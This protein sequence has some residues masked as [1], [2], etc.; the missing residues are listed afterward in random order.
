MYDFRN[1]LH[2][3]EKAQIISLET[4]LRWCPKVFLEW[5]FSIIQVITMSY[6]SELFTNRG[7]TG[8]V[9][10]GC[11]PLH[12]EILI[13]MNEM[14]FGYQ[15]H[16]WN[17]NWFRHVHWNLLSVQILLVWSK[18]NTKGNLLGRQCF[19][20]ADNVG[21]FMIYHSKSDESI[22]E[23]INNIVFFLYKTSYNSIVITNLWILYLKKK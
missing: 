15:N 4:T 6:D 14:I 17:K 5:S 16:T 11:N 2:V 10:L 23:S 12:W 19:S 9:I 13:C 8:L 21:N 1:I 7:E 20:I 3:D 22:K 18:D